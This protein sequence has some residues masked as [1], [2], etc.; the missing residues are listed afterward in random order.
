[1]NKEKDRTDKHRRTGIKEMR[2]R[3]NVAKMGQKTNKK[4]KQL[5]INKQQQTQ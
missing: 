1:V 3:K 2:I 5:N 4:A